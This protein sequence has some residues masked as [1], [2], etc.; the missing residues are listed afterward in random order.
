MANQVSF[1]RKEGDLSTMTYFLVEQLNLGS[2]SVTL[3]AA[4][5]NMKQRVAEYVEQMFPGTTQTPV[6]VDNLSPPFFLRP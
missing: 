6:L 2:E 1:E 3:L 5:E 4:Y